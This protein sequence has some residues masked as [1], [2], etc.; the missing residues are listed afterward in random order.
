MINWLAYTKIPSGAPPLEAWDTVADKTLAVDRYQGWSYPWLDVQG[1]IARTERVLQLPN[2]DRD[3]IPRWSFSRVTLIGDAAHPMQPV[4]A[5]AGSQAIVDG[6]VLAASLLASADAVE[7][8][9]RYQDQRI[10]AMNDMIIRN[11]NLGLETVLQ[12]AEERAPDGFGH[13]ADVLSH[14]ELENTAASFK[15]AAGFDLETVNSRQ[16]YVELQR[17]AIMR[18]LVPSRA[19]QC[20]TPAGGRM[21]RVLFALFLAGAMLLEPGPAA[22]QTYPAR[23]VHMVVTFPPGGN[24]DTIARL[25]AD[26]LTQHLR[27]PVIVENKPGAASIVGT[28]AVVQAPADG[29]TLLQVGTNVSTNPALGHKTSY[30]AER[31]LEPVA[32]LVTVPA[33][34]VV[35][36]SL[37]VNTLAEL[38]VHAKSRP[39]E[40]NYGSAGNGSFPHLAMEKLAQDTGIKMTHVPFRGFGPALIGLLR[41]DVNV[42]ASDIP[43]ALEH[44]RAGKLRALAV[45]GSTRMP[46]LPGVPTV[47]EV[48]VPE[49]EGVGF[50]GI[51]VR[52][53][54]P[55]DVIDVLNREINRALAI[56]RDRQP[57][58]CQRSRR[59]QRDAR[60]L[61]RVPQARQGGLDQGHRHRRHQ[62]R[63]SRGGAGAAYALICVRSCTSAAPG[64]SCERG[65]DRYSP[66][67]AAPRSP[68]GSAS[69]SPPPRRSG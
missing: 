21:A 27:Q 37:P 38:V 11:R 56:A 23:Q 65:C 63:V 13:I 59:R 4:G 61:R 6:R 54:T 64:T 10:A 68:R 16:S 39:G 29:H 12:I 62:G 24:A 67:R 15:K 41:N 1:L 22:S 51:M 30:D 58:R 2:V 52:A 5:Q 57:H 3:P 25:V 48:G 45:T 43:G 32:L 49:Y 17:P 50:V 34:V 60:G 46:M 20:Q 36:P 40:V 35:H 55:R 28:T 53:G 26:K 31:D 44:V 9:V 14:D 7:A 33:V 42:L 66:A 19:Q 18:H 69:P 8:L 47:A